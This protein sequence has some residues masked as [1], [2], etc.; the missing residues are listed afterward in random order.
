M[1]GYLY[2]DPVDVERNQ[3][4]INWFIEEGKI[5]E[6]DIL[7][8]TS[9]AYHSGSLPDFV[10]NRSREPEISRF[11]AENNVP[12]FNSL[13]VTQITNDKWATYLH[14]KDHVKMLQTE[15]YHKDFKLPAIVK[16]R[17]GHGGTD[18]H[19][20]NDFDHSFDHQYIIQDIAPVIGKDLR[21]YILGNQIL[22]CVLRTSDSDFKSNYSLGGQIQRYELSKAEKDVVYS[23]LE[24]MPIDYG[25]ID[26]LFDENQQLI[27]NEI[28]DAVGARMLY[29]LSNYNIV[30]LY[31]SYIRERLNV[32]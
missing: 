15:V 28:E 12:V 14:F 5:L 21:V 24:I 4:F 18:V 20:I 27:L 30:S 19:W 8:K 13:E 32:N 10:I 25:G 11:Y 1:I 29:N 7:L 9:D 2:Y 3:S 6:M 23:I 31:L 22:D 17:F 26:F 16:H